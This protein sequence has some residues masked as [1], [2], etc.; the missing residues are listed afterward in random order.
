MLNSCA[1]SAHINKR[2]LRFA[3]TRQ[4]LQLRYLRSC[5]KRSLCRAF[6]YALVVLSSRRNDSSYKAYNIIIE[7]ARGAYFSTQF[8]SFNDGILSNSRLLFVTNIKFLVIA[9]AAICI[10]YA[11]ITVP[12]LSKY[13]RIAPNASASSVVKSRK[14]NSFTKSSNACLLF[15][16]LLLL[17]APYCNSANE[18]VERYIALL[19]IRFNFARTYSGRLF[20]IYM[21][22]FVSSK[23]TTYLPVAVCSVGFFLL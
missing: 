20:M 9:C 5:K 2:C 3:Q 1:K 11:P 16:G 7:A 17:Y 19:S 22:I 23:Y 21:Q 10:S 13:A 8:S 18:I 6:F 15:C 12:F 4:C 14:V